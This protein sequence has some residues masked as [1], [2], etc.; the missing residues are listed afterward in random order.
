[1]LTTLF[2]F[3]TSNPRDRTTVTTL[4]LSLNH[5]IVFPQEFQRFHK[6][7]MCHSNFTLRK[8]SG[9]LHA[10]LLLKWILWLR[11]L[12]C[13]TSLLLT[14]EIALP[15]L[16][17]PYLL[18]TEYF[19]PRNFSV[20]IKFV[21]ATV[22]S[23][24]GSSVESYMLYYPVMLLFG[25]LPQWNIPVNC[26]VNGTTSQSGLRTQTGSSSLWVSRKVALSFFGFKVRTC[27]FFIK[28]IFILFYSIFYSISM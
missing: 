2:Y 4:L 18:S 26:H 14:L 11:S 28:F 19:F 12:H 5:Q 20:S 22:I 9:V 21:C 24:S 7:C 8:F 6:L 3:S 17:C 16:R 1:M 15:S 13:F 23:L 25:K 27:S 10:L